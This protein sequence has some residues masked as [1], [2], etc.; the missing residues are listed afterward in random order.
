MCLLWYVAIDDLIW[1]RDVT[2]LCTDFL[3]LS[4][5][6]FHFSA[7]FWFYLKHE[8]VKYELHND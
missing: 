8:K 4:C 6:D 3:I 7:P 2:I 1:I 5:F